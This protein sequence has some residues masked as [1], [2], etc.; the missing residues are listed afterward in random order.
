L[1]PTIDRRYRSD[2]DIDVDMKKA[3]P[4]SNQLRGSLDVLVLKAL[5]LEPLHG[6][7]LFRR[8]Q[9]IT[10]RA[11][12]VSY[13]SLFPAL[14]RMERRGWLNAEWRTSDQN[15]RAKYYRLTRLGRK[16]LAREEREWR[17]VVGAVMLALGSSEPSAE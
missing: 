5:S 12:E 2:L 13:G 14:H 3:E 16:E 7:G 4:R 15:R 6:V 1:T 11:I 9:Q 8:I 17:R 10:G